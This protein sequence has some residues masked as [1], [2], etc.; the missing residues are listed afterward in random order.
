MAS[1]FATFNDVSTPEGRKLWELATKP[2]KSEFDGGKSGYPLFKAQVRNKLRTC[3]WQDINT[4]TIGG[5]VLSLVDNADLIP[6]E[7]VVNAREQRELYI[8][9][10]PRQA[11]P[12]N[13][14]T[15]IT[16]AQVTTATLHAFQ[17]Q[18]QHDCL[19]GSLSGDMEQHVAELQNQNK[20]HNDGPTLLKLIQD[21]ARGKAVRQQ[22]KN[23]R[24]RIRD[25]SLKEHKWNVTAFNDQLKSLLVTLRNNE[26]EFLDK[27]IADVVVN[28]YKQVKHQDFAS[29]IT[30]ELNV[31]DKAN[32]DVDHEELM[33][34]GEAKYESLVKQGI[35]GK[36]TP[37]EEQILALQTQLKALQSQQHKGNKPSPSKDTGKDNSEEPKKKKYQDKAPPEWKLENPDN[38]SILKKTIKFK[39]KEE[40]VTYHWCK[41]HRHGKGMWVRHKPKDCKL[42]DK[43]KDKPETKAKLVAA[44]TILDE[45]SDT[46]QE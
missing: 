15:E 37:Q 2:L 9:T 11:D 44:K 39:G 28:N 12:Q 21:K 4:F 25:L 38:K 3:Q 46:D 33:E 10:G 5:Q 42:K 23:V 27:D 34:I 30:L 22:M 35:W 17:A 14:V 26:E 40:E 43:E 36:R 8:V 32:R 31:A 18:M 6:L 16:N 13:G 24:Q 29:M 1:P 45:G 7:E 41:H 19:V 20:T